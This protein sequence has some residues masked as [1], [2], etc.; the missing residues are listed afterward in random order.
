MSDQRAADR[1]GITDRDLI[2]ATFDAIGALARKLTG[3]Q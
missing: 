2:V 1:S 3:A